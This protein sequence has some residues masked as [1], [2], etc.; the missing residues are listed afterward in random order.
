[1]IGNVP[2]KTPTAAQS[3][4]KSAGKTGVF[5]PSFTPTAAS[6]DTSG[7]VVGRKVMHTKFGEGVIVSVNGEGKEKIAGIE[8]PGLGIKKFVVAVAM[9]NMRLL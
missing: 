6:G 5:R 2:V 8:F 1:M 3:E 9:A 4:S 7:Y